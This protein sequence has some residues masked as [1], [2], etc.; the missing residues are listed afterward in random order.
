MGKERGCKIIGIG[1]VGSYKGLTHKLL[2]NGKFTD[3][4]VSATGRGIDGITP[5]PVS[6][7]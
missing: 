3:I 7:A 2:D 1:T 5:C 4:E 6:A